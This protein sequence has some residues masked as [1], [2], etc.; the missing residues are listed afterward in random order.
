MSTEQLLE[1]A[2]QDADEA[3][4]QEH[5]RSLR[6]VFNAV[7][8]PRF[9]KGR[10]H[11]ISAVLALAF[12]AVLA[13]KRNCQQIAHFGRMNLRLLTV[14]GFLPAKRPRRKDRKGVVVAPSHDTIER[15]LSLVRADQF[16]QLVSRWVGRRICSGSCGAID[17]KAL[18]GSGGYVLSVYVTK[19]R[20]TVWQESI[21]SKE[22]ELSALERC[23]PKILE[24]CPAIKVFTGDAGLCHKSIAK[25]LV[26]HGRDYVLQLKA[27]HT[28]DVGIAHD[29]FRQLTRLPPL[30]RTEEKRGA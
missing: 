25:T 10:R 11:C 7:D 24:N 30:A 18:R 1:S 23:L 6:E 9:A 22:N 27:P 20:E 19:I 5:V 16:N 15:L 21:G 3:T 14:L 4:E 26:E 17:G 29:S 13:G 8:D 2:A 12:I 28:T